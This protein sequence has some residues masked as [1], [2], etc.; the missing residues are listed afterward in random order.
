MV[1][2]N[3]HERALERKLDRVIELLEEQNK[4]LLTIAE[5]TR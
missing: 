2:F 5:H 1:Q 3:R 4:L